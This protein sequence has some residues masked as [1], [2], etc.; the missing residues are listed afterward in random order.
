[1]TH[2]TIAAILGGPEMIILGVAILLLFGGKKIPE[3]MRG[4]GKGIKEF[5]N[6]QEGTEEPKV[7]KEV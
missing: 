4:L 5:K 3:L 7:Q 6:G 1:M 2:S